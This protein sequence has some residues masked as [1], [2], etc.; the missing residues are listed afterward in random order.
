MKHEA[1]T[2]EQIAT[3]SLMEAGIY[4][5]E[6]A[7][8][9]EK[10]SAKGNEMLE[11]KVNVYETDGT[12][13]P[14]RDWI[15]PQMAKKFKHFHDATDMMDKYKTG[16]L[17]AAD[18]IGKTGKCMI[19]VSTYK[20]KDGLDITNNKIDDYVKRGSTQTYKEAALPKDVAD[21]EIPF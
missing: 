1:K 8:A 9:E 7:G 17:V 3:D 15:L 18:V 19:V 14:M 13:R 20:N 10:V 6:V 12:I 21:D 2:D 16:S 4:D 5:F 11:L